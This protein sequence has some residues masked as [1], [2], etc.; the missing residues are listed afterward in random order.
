MGMTRACTVDLGLLAYGRWVSG[1]KGPLRAPER[2]ARPSFPS[3]TQHGLLPCLS[4]PQFQSSIV[5]TA[6]D[7]D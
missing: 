6:G 7:C 4:Q 1:Q 3:D 5:P 2:E